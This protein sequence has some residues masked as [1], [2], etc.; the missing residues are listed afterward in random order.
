MCRPKRIKG[1]VRGVARMVDE[2]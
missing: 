1:Q 2:D